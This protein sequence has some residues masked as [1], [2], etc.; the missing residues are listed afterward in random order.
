[1]FAARFSI[2]MKKVIKTTNCRPSEIIEAA[3]GGRVLYR[4]NFGELCVKV[5]TWRRL[6]LSWWF[7]NIIWL[8]IWLGLFFKYVYPAFDA[9]KSFM[10]NLLAHD[11]TYVFIGGT[12][13]V[14]AIKYAIK[15]TFRH[16]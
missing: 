1:M 4:E 8:A 9:T 5:K 7:P 13:V 10:S 15:Q 3:Q 2:N 6:L 12:F 14:N 16:D 11:F